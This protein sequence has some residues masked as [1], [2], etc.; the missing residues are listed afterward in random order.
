VQVNDGSLVPGEWPEPEEWNPRNN[1]ERGELE[2]GVGSEIVR[3]L[4]NELC[5]LFIREL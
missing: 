3:K 1:P 5:L 4:E 2:A